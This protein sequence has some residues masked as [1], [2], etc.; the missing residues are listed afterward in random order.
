MTH[1]MLAGTERV[2]V[3]SGV[4]LLIVA[5]WCDIATRTVPNQI[6]AALAGIGIVLRM[7]A[8]DLLIALAVACV[9]FLLAFFCWRR[10]WLGGGDVK[11]F[12]AAALLV[13]PA[14][15]PGLVIDTALAGGMLAL[16]YLALQAVLPAPAPARPAARL[17]RVLRVEQWRIRHR[18]PLPYAS[19][20]AAGAIFVL[21]S[22]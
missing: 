10:G 9:V 11:L 8:G 14:R 7:F 20:I 3:V 1:E 22:R 18:A 12:A 17:A 5:G 16:L 6:P 15:V 4:L 13:A 2:I 21:L 19:A